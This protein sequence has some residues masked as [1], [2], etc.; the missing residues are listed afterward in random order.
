MVRARQLC[1]W[2][3]PQLSCPSWACCL[4]VPDGIPQIPKCLWRRKL[5]LSPG[6]HQCLCPLGRWVCSQVK[7]LC[8]GGSVLLLMGTSRD[9]ATNIPV[10]SQT[11]TAR[12]ARR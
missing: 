11:I 6:T 7:S 1:C 4:Q 3:V 10:A 12:Q 9:W 8:M 2:K 5:G